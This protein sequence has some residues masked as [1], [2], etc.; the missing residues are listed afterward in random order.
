MLLGVAQALPH[1][2]DRGHRVGEVDDQIEEL[3]DAQRAERLSKE[4]LQ[5]RAT[6]G[7]EHARV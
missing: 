6:Q 7:C 3:S 1:V 5:P 4:E 2:E